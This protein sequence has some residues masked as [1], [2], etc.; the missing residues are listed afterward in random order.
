MVGDDE[1]RQRKE[2]RHAKDAVTEKIGDPI[3]A[4][5]YVE[6]RGPYRIVR[7]QHQDSRDTAEARER[8]NVGLGRHGENI[9]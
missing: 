7:S 2:R 8:R 5:L 4:R 6:G 1:A 3:G 9:A